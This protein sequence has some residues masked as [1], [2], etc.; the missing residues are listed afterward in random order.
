MQTLR[1]IYHMMRADFLERARRSSF[2]VILGLAALAGFAYIPPVDSSTLAIAL[3]PWRGINNSAWIGV[4]FGLLTVIII[5]VLGYFLVKNAI[6]RDR[7]THVGQ[8]IA[9]TPISKP[10]YI[11]GKWLSNLATLTS[12]LGVLN[13]MALLMQ[14]LRAEVLTVD[15]WALSAPIWLMGFPVI[16]LVA[17]FAIWFE[18]VSFLSGSFGNVVYFIGWLLFLSNI[19][20]PGIFSF[21]I[22]NVQ[23]FNDILG[24][25][26]PLAALQVIGNQV[27]PEFAGHFNF[28]GAEYGRMPEVV[29]WQGMEWTTEYMLGRLYWLTFAFIFAFAAAL[30]F[31]RFDPARAFTK[32][33]PKLHVKK[34]AVEPAFIETTRKQL[35][36]LADTVSQFRFGAMLIAELKLMFK[37]QRWWWYLAAAFISLL[38][39]AGPP[40]GGSVTAQL[41]VLWPVVVLSALG[42]RESF[43]DTSRL[44]YSSSSLFRGQFWASWFSGVVL[45]L[46]ALIPVSLRLLIEGQPDRLLVFIV[47]A[48][49]IPS[50][51]M[52][53]GSWS[54]TPRLFEA[55]YLPLW[56][57]GAN[58][59]KPLDF[60]QASSDVIDPIMLVVYLSLSIVLIGAA[61]IKKQ[62]QLIAA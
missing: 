62:S 58:G 59:V 21:N 36:P 12:M 2:L 55:L 47:A 1:L 32:R 50:L 13:L 40:G 37:G 49:F 23:P 15:L 33:V 6:E 17:A 8:I 52:T 9:T 18:A 11:I 35:S 10:V 30:P 20:L 46:L 39:L 48:V 34:A 16:A 27:S 4:V 25:T 45:I 53:L 43:F 42:A 22:G 54:G 29:N 3:G 5:P 61:V 60:M 7:Q 51:A 26:A 38:G 19:A 56:F 44:I 28:G 14:I 31:D 57:I 24:V 41:A